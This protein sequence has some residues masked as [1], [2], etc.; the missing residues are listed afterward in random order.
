MR[1]ILLK[2]FKISLHIQ[3]QAKLRKSIYVCVM[4]LPM[5]PVLFMQFVYTANRIG[6]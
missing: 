1:V 6:R 3:M 4:Y 2:A 5:N